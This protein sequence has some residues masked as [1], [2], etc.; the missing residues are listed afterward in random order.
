MH[1][2]DGDVG[3]E[4][5]VET[6]QIELLVNEFRNSGQLRVQFQGTSFADWVPDLNGSNVLSEA[7]LK[8]NRNLR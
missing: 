5:P 8:C 7:F 1:F 3:L 2:A 4:F 6:D